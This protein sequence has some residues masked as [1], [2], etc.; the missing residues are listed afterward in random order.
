MGL[1][2]VDVDSSL[3]TQPSSG[4]PDISGTTECMVEMWHM[5]IANM[6]VTVCTVAWCVHDYSAYLQLKE[7]IKHKFE[8]I[9]VNVDQLKRQIGMFKDIDEQI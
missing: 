4:E 5:L 3:S 9:C 7:R 1:A 8:P 2:C 6:A